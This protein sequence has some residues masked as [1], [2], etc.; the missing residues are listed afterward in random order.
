MLAAVSALGYRNG[1]ENPLAQFGPGSKPAQLGLFT[2]E[3]ILALPV[4]Q[5]PAS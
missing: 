2:P 1:A 4:G 5:A 3:S